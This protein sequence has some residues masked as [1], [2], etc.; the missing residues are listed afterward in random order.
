MAHKALEIC[1]HMIKYATCEKCC[2]LYSVA[3][4]LT[5]KPNLSLKI[6]HCTF[7]G[8]PNHP[9]ANKR[10]PC[11]S[12]IAKKVSVTGGVIFKPILIFLTISLVHQLQSLYNRKRF[13]VNCRKWVDRLV[14]S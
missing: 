2:K 6:S 9:M 14:D 8:F 10:Q 7:Q 4:V 3:D 1:A 13:E 12:P 5:D 11:T